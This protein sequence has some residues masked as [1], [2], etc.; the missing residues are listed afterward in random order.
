MNPFGFLGVP[1]CSVKGCGNP[2]IVKVMIEGS[3]GK[4]WAH[5]CVLCMGETVECLGELSKIAHEKMPLL[6]EP[7]PAPAQEEAL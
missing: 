1:D 2:G 5:L 6:P 4:V 3:E 7:E